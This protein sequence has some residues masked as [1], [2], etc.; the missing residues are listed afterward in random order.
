[1]ERLTVDAMEHTAS[2]N[3]AS[4][5]GGPAPPPLAVRPVARRP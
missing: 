4:A 5:P 1:V 2:L 3:C